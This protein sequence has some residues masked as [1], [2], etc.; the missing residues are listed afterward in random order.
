MR[1][2]DPRTSRTSSTASSV[3]LG[4]GAA[5]GCSRGA[6][7]GAA[8]D[9]VEP[10][11]GAGRRLGA[12]RHVT[13]GGVR[14]GARRSGACGGARNAR[15]RAARPQLPARAAAGRRQ[16][17]GDDSAF[18][19]RQLRATDLHH[20]VGAA[21]PF[22]PRVDI[23]CA[24]VSF[25]VPD[26]VMIGDRWRGSP[27]VV[28]SFAAGAVVQRL[29]DSACERATQ[30]SPPATATPRGDGGRRR[31]EPRQAAVVGLG[32]VDA[33]KPG[34]KA[35]PQARATR[36]LRPNEDPEE[37]TRARQ[38][39]G[40][41]ASYSLVDIRD[42]SNV[43]DWYPQDHPP[44]P[45][46]SSG[47]ARPGRAPHAAGCGFWRLPNGLGAAGRADGCAAAR[48]LRPADVAIPEGA[49]AQR[50]RA[51]RTPDTMIDLARAM[52]VRR[53]SRPRLLRG[54]ADGRRASR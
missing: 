53:S 19:R 1:G 47:W 25:D 43:A 6:S 54:R 11:T 14:H 45:D 21:R 41:S 7:A 44:M 16:L 24:C 42:S 12:L 13:T 51:R 40:S 29:Y 26:E 22:W 32:F 5:P 28:I 20:R 39:P 15:R 2:C 35:K 37:Q 17:G 34:D 52:T 9:A 18:G 3:L 49:A 50:D 48:L 33:P 10:G 4:L 23:D 38:L 8:S 31:R 46:I 30:S 36:N 27:D